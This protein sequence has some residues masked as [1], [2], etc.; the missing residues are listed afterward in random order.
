MLSLRL[1]MKDEPQI[2]ENGDWTP[3]MPKISKCAELLS[4][5][6]VAAA[7]YFYMLVNAFADLLV[8]IPVNQTQ[9]HTTINTNS[10]VFGKILAMYGVIESQGRG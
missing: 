2:S 10:G 6:P 5:N 8:G 7:R 9:K 4:K 1:V 3:H